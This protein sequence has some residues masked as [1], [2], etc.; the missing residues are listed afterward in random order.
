MDPP[1]ALQFRHPRAH[2]SQAA[3]E[4]VFQALQDLAADAAH[5]GDGHALQVVEDSQTQ[6]TEDV[7]R[8]GAEREGRQARVEEEG[9]VEPR[10]AAGGGE[11]EG[12]EGVAAPG[13]L[14]PR[15]VRRG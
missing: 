1:Q 10:Q 6:S 5:A 9:E 13:L 8:E 14:R 12:E 7:D 11:D 3:A 4:A 15:G 2:G